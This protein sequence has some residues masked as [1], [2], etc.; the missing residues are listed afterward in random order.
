MNIKIYIYNVYIKM[1]HITS[2]EL[3]KFYSLLSSD[4]EYE[5]YLSN[6]AQ[7]YY[8]YKKDNIMKYI[9]KHKH[10]QQK[11]EAFDLGIMNELSLYNNITLEDVLNNL[12]LKWDWQCITGHKNISYSTI[13]KYGG[14]P[15]DYGGILS[16]KNIPFEELKTYIIEKNGL[17]RNNWVNE[18]QEKEK[19]TNMTLVMLTQNK[20]IAIDDIINNKEINWPYKLLSTNCNIPWNY[21]VENIHLC[22]EFEYLFS[23]PTNTWEEIKEYGKKIFDDFDDK[24]ILSNFSD[25]TKSY[26]SKNKNITWDIIIKNLHEEWDWDYITINPNITMKII[27]DYPDKKWNKNKLYQNITIDICEYDT[28]NIKISQLEKYKKKFGFVMDEFDY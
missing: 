25:K 10:N 18:I 13:K 5:K 20:G 27:N 21:I 2:N 12:E 19:E 9:D 14:I 1:S 15:W 16:N 8:N 3:L 7:T 6:E 26:I 24:N 28:N 22:W 23:R 17:N 4:E 11:K